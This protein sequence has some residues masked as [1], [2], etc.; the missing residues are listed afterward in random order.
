[1]IKEEM[2]EEEEQQEEQFDLGLDNIKEEKEWK[3]DNPSAEEK[4]LIHYMRY[5]A[6]SFDWQPEEKEQRKTQDNI[7]EKVEP[8]NQ[9]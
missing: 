7:E 5:R 3:A 2:I 8:K 1:M 6:D 9:S 4:L